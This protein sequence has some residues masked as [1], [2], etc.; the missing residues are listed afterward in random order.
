M[1]HSRSCNKQ[2]NESGKCVCGNQASI[3]RQNGKIT[4]R[5]LYEHEV[6]MHQLTIN[7]HKIQLS[8]MQQK[9]YNQNLQIASLIEQRDALNE[10]LRILEPE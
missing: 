2:R 5:E 1:I 9:L 8:D 10:Q 3:D 4:V 7:N 6:A